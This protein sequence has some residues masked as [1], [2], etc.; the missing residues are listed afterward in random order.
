MAKVTRKS[1]EPDT[2]MDQP[3]SSTREKEDEV[4]KTTRKE[5]RP[6]KRSSSKKASEKTT[7]TPMRKPKKVKGPI[8]FGHYHRLNENLKKNEPVQDH[9]SVENSTISSGH[10]ESQ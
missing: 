7:I 1:P 9:K 4:S 2:D 10:L 6:L 5:K 3:T 8:L